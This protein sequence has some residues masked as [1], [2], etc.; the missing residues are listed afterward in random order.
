MI[1]QS[2]YNLKID[3]TL[4]RKLTKAPKPKITHSIQFNN[5]LRKN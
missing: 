5:K 1:Y 4:T 3:K 2:D